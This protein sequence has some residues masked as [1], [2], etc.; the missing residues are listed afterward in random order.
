MNLKVAIIPM[1]TFVFMILFLLG[2]F[3]H[4]FYNS[5][6]TSDLT[7]SDMDKVISLMEQTNL[8]DIANST[9]DYSSYDAT[10]DTLGFSVAIF[11]DNQLLHTNFH[12]ETSYLSSYIKTDIA[13]LQDTPVVTTLN[14]KRQILLHR[15]LGE[16]DYYI[17][18]RSTSTKLSSLLGTDAFFYTFVFFLILLIFFIFKLCQKYSK[19]LTK[20][21]MLPIKQL[22]E[23]AKRIQEGNL[24]VNLDY[25]TKDEF[26]PVFDSFNEMQTRLKESILLRIDRE[27]EQQEMIA[28]ISHD[29]KTPLTS[30]KGYVKGLEDGVASTPEKQAHYL[31][32]IRKKTDDMSHLIDEILIYSRLTRNK[33]AFNSTNVTIDTYLQEVLAIMQEDND[34]QLLSIE[35]KPNAPSSIVRLD[36]L[37]FNRVLDNIIENSKKYACKEH[38][39]VTVSTRKRGNSVEIT[40]KD[41]G[42]GVANDKLSHIFDTF[43]RADDSR[44]QSTNG[45]GLGLAITKHIIEKLS[46]SITA[47]NNDGL[48]IIITLKE[49]EYATHTD[50]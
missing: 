39:I 27:K 44:N 17:I 18:V 10:F 40:I 15:S 30:I 34:E 45:T 38:T 21:L 12:G 4:A 11:K 20:Q 13:K 22:G 49:A 43:Y 35:F 5:L 14:R 36:P 26:E 7:D 9:V 8:A 41:N 31:M 1:I 25:T 29:L 6:S 19:R 28:E 2:L 42:Y 48:C 47:K 33:I 46:G 32:K 37:Q 16:S 3:R 24:D 23:G 50:H